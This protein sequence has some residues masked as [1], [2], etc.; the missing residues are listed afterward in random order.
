MPSLLPM[1]NEYQFLV[2]IFCH[3]FQSEYSSGLKSDF[4]KLKII[5]PIERGQTYD[6]SSTFP[7]NFNYS[8]YTPS[9]S[10]LFI[11][12]AIYW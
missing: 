9:V 11:Y 2:V 7:I 10:V 4:Y 5:L 8:L 1:A 12:L 6:I 3:F